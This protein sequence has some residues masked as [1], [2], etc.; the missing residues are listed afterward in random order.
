MS[1]LYQKKIKK[2]TIIFTVFSLLW[3]TVIIFRLVQLQ[4]L[5][6]N[7]LKAEVNV[8]NRSIHTIQPKRGTIYDCQGE[9][10]ARS[11]PTPSI[12]YTPL[13]DESPEK[14]ILKI[15]KLKTVISLSNQDLQ[16]IKK[17][18]KA[19]VPF[20]WVK[21]KITP[22]QA[23]KVKKLHLKGIHFTE[24]TKRFYPQG[25]LA[26]QILGRVDIDDSGASG[27]ELKYN[28]QLAGKKGKRLILR[29]AKQRKYH[30]ET[31][32]EPVPGNDLVLT[33]NST[34]EY[35]A[36]TE[37]A[38]TV[39]EKKAKWGTVI[40]SNPVSGEILAMAN[41]PTYDLNHLPS[42]PLLIDR[43]QAIHNIFDPGST[44]KIVTAAAAMESKSVA[45]DQ[46]FDC[47][48]QVISLAGKTFRDYHKFGLLSF[49][50]V[51]IHSS[52]VGTIQIG[53]QI[54]SKVLYQTIKSFG[55][56]Q[57]TGIDLPAEEKGLLRPPNQWS[58]ISKASL[59]IGYEI[60]VT[61]LQVLQA[62]N[63]VANKGVVAKPKIVKAMLSSNKQTTGEPAYYRRVISESTA[64]TLI[65]IL[66]KAVEGGTGQAAQIKGYNIA[67][68]TG[69]AQKFN[70]VTGRYSSSSHTAS[71]VGFVWDKK[72]IFSMIVVIDDPQGQY[73]GG[74]VSAPIWRRIASQILRYLGIPPQLEGTK[75]IIAA[76][77]WRLEN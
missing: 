49:P 37:L 56:G 19:D 32:E 36:E 14:Q 45:L 18:I 8:Q 23:Q 4:V 27:V 55:F 22:A 60:S 1:S 39:R 20:I 54:D 51:I 77:P 24:E 6:H 74:Q 47:S 69:T 72:P 11:I 43:I 59:S 25:R 66:K 15:K 12:Y 33:I 67:G 48:S 5:K 17:R 61:A 42:N 38:K 26:A 40:I 34:I 30:F 16:K 35:I 31:L 73:Y 46:V 68:K 2:R 52:N 21:R 57:K 65:S 58:K 63:T 53:Q 9:I 10:L 76:N 71:F 28:S 29:D 44:F 70:P 13:K 50:E 41:Y 64:N 3:V 62:I 75:T 7:Q